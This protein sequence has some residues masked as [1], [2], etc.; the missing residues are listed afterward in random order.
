MFPLSNVPG[1]D[2]SYWRSPQL[3]SKNG[4]CQR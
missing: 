3:M 2:R 1:H 4:E